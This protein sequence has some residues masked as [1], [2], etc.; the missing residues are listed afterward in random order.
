MEK[1]IFLGFSRYYTNK[2]F[3]RA[4]FWKK[5]I[6]FCLIKLIFFNKK[7]GLILELDD[8]YFKEVDFNRRSINLKYSQYYL[9]MHED[10]DNV[11]HIQ[12]GNGAGD[13]LMHHCYTYFK[14][15]VR[16][17]NCMNYSEWDFYRLNN[18]MDLKFTNRCMDNRFC[19]NCKKVDINRFILNFMDFY[20]DLVN[21]Y[22]PY[23]LTL[24]VPNVTGDLLSETLSRMSKCFSRLIKYLNKCYVYPFEIAGGVKVLELTY[25][26]VLNT[27]HPHYHCLVLFKKE[28]VFNYSFFFDCTYRHLFSKKNNDYNYISDYCCYVIKIW[29]LIWQGKR[30]SKSNIGLYNFSPGDISCLDV[31]WLQCDLVKLDQRG[32]FEIFKYTF[33]DVDIVN[34]R[35]FKTISKALCRRRLRQG[36]GIFYNLK[37]EDISEK[38]IEPLV[39]K[40]KEDPE[41]LI[42]KLQDLLLGFTD[43]KKVSRKNS[44]TVIFE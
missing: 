3:F 31:Q 29:S 12:I 16:I 33:K 27:Y 28:V 43:V 20:K 36:F 35:V 1:S 25:N 21:D 44:D 23:M 2:L 26:S 40:Q 10:F 18:V 8:E 17:K 6:F 4:K 37:C 24:T 11:Y 41:L 32:V 30:L 39:L 38:D 15:S 22:V 14:K 13:A 42:L 9:K 34:Y 19:P 5:P 7:G